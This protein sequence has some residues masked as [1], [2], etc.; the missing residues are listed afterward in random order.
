MLGCL[1]PGAFDVFVCTEFKR[2]HVC[3]T[4]SVAQR[5]SIRSTE[6]FKVFEF[7]VE[8][9]TLL[10]SQASPKYLGVRQILSFCLILLFHKFR[11]AM[12]L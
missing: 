12:R 8:L 5:A 6:M 11:H 9:L 1:G 2:W 10:H 7:P 3:F 4:A